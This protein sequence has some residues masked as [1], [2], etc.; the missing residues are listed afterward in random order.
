MSTTVVS[1]EQVIQQLHWRYATKKFDPARK[2]PEADWKTL[3]QTLVLA[4]SSFGL[5]PWK[6]FV[7]SNPEIRQQ[8]VEHSWG[9]KQVVEASHLVVLAIKRDL[10]SADV[11]RYVE[12]MAEVRQVPVSSLEGFGNVIKGFMASP[13]YP[14]DINEWSKRQVYIAL[15]QLMTS[16]AFMGIDTCPM[17]GFNPT[18]YDEILGLAEKGYSSVVIC[19]VG[20]RAEDDQY[21]D[22]PKVRYP[23]DD[24][25][26]Y[27][28]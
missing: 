6:F 5:Q 20:Y 9:Q 1:P 4:P 21:A 25:V 27:I 23:S 3:E 13:P 2:I 11:D 12:Y 22:L 7:V 15:G 14:L 19:P 8:L 17:E 18:K 24:V 16:A 26:E 10:S 28:S